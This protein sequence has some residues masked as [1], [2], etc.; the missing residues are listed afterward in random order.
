MRMESLQMKI[1]I[2]TSKRSASI[3]KLVQNKLK[4]MKMEFNMCG[5]LS[6]IG[7]ISM[8]FNVVN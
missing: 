5:N 3:N 6:I 1:A 4:Q 8:S 2:K 7:L